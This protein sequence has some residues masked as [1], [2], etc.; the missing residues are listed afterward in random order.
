[1]TEP[2]PEPD[3]PGEQ[4]EQRLAS[5]S[6]AAGDPIGWFEDLYAAGVGGRIQVPWSRTEPHPM[7]TQWTSEQQLDGLDRN[8]IVVGCA[9]GA[10]A[11][12]IVGL[13]FDTVAFDVS[14]TAIRLA[15]QR[16][17]DSSVRYVTADLLD[18]PPDWLQAFDLVIEVITVQ[19]LPDPP[20]RQA[21]VNV[22]RLVA[23]GGTLLVIAWSDDDRAPPPPPWPLRRGEIDAF[24]IDGLTTQHVEQVALPGEQYELRWRVQFRRD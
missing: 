6:L 15:R 14:H 5:R 1:M 18:P 12:H 8:A 19:A 9:L 24:A 3:D 10:D 4:E 2:E 17:P 7:L 16:H 11:E 23:P 13:G 20:R 22:G 21:I